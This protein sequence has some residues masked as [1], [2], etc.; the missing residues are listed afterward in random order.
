[1][2]TRHATA[3][4]AQEEF[5]PLLTLHIS[6]ASRSTQH[7]Y[8]FVGA[9][10]LCLETFIDLGTIAPWMLNLVNLSPPRD[11]SIACSNVDLR[12]PSRCRMHSSGALFRL[13]WRFATN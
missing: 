12:T 6:E 4:L 2:Q 1:M 8:S 10:L 9:F 11:Q 7:T 3:H 13:T 5:L